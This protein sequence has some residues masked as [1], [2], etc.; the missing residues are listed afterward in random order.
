MES[1]YCDYITY[2]KTPTISWQ[3]AQIDMARHQRHH[4][5]TVV[6]GQLQGNSIWTVIPKSIKM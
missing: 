2:T 5:Y 1:N 4:L 6:K 3:I